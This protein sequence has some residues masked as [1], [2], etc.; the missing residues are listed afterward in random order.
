M[1]DRKG[2]TDRINCQDVVE[3][4][5]GRP[6]Y[7]S[8]K[9]HLYRCPF[10]HEQK[11]YSL[12]VYSDGWTCYGACN[13]SGDAVKF[14]EMRKDISWNEACVELVNRYNLPSD[15]AGNQQSGLHRHRRPAARPAV[16]ERRQDE[17]M[18]PDRDWQSRARE[19]VKLAEETLWSPEGK[20]GLHYLRT[21]RGLPEWIIRQARLGYIPATRNE[22]YTYGR[23]LLPYWQLDG[24]P[25]RAHCG[26]TIPH[27]AGRDLWAVRVRRPPGLDGPKYIG[28]RGGSKAL[29]WSDEIEERF[30]VIITEGEFDALCLY[31]AA[32]E[33]ASTVSIAS[34]SNK[35]IAARWKARLLTAPI[36][37]ARMD[38]DGAGNKAA[39]LLGSS[40][41]RLATI[42][43]PAPYKDVNEF[44]LGAGREA[45]QVWVEESLNGNA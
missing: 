19:L 9:A 25:V 20:R 41:S 34:A 7:R 22:D 39:A 3:A 31:I 35:E 2:I 15:L 45:V 1:I 13:M 36:I 5:L 16:V 28:V 42:Q 30:P 23:V 12:A 33:H 11:G 32:Y 37:L 18:P 44:F 29:Y 21:Q 43:V 27:F 10:H 8:G 14:L 4:E 40:F 26:I 24:K 17:D 6:K 38:G